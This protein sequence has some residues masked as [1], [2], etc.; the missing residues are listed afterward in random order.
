M[1]ERMSLCVSTTIEERCSLSV[2]C[3]RRSSRGAASVV[4]RRVSVTGTAFIV[5][6][7][8][9]STGD[10]KVSSNKS[11][12]MTFSLFIGE[13]IYHKDTKTQ[14]ELKNDTLDAIFKEG[15]VKVD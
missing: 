4:A 3:H 9:G 5:S 12:S 11:S 2:F 14:R 15:H 10:V 1:I 6:L 13:M 7:L 8:C